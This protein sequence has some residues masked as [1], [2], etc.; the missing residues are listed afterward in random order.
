MNVLTAETLWEK[1]MELVIMMRQS[2]SLTFTYACA[3]GN[4]PPCIPGSSGPPLS[5]PLSA[6]HDLLIEGRQPGPLS[7]PKSVLQASTSLRDIHTLLP[8]SEEPWCAPDDH[9]GGQCSWR[10]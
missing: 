6:Y 8:W 2:E 1:L 10:S 4:S 9:C 5:R 7:G 3:I